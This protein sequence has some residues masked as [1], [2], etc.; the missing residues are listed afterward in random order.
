MEVDPAE[1]PLLLFNEPLAG[2]APAA[3]L[4]RAEE[5]RSRHANGATLLI[6]TQHLAVAADLAERAIVLAEGRITHDL[7]TAELL[8]R[9]RVHRYEVRLRG[10]LPPDWGDFF[11]GFTLM[12]LPSGEC[13]LRG[14]IADQ[15]ALH[16][17][18]ATIRALVL[19]LCAVQRI[20]P[21]LE[22]LI[23]L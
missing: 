22:A 12:N 19:E 14:E 23:G 6:A 9:M 4:Q 11:D 5:L 18:I 7:P 16:G 20:D 15:A 13:L 3:A 21:S 8:R 1:T 17:L 10:H 2:L